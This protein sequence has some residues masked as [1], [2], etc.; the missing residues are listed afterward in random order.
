MLTK[1]FS[2]TRVSLLRILLFSSGGFHLRELSR[3]AGVSAPYASKELAN[4]MDA[5]IVREEKVGNLKVYSVREG[6]P[7]LPE[8]RGLFIKTD[9]L[10][11]LVREK[12]SEKAR[13][14]L[15]YGSFA[16]GDE[17]EGSDIDL[18]VV[19]GM[20]EDNLL[21]LSKKLEGETSREVNY[22][23]WNDKAFKE[24]KGNALLKTI[25][26]QGFIMIIGDEQEFRKEAS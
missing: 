2:K 6:C 17:R 23:L 26:D 16:K 24:R 11:E 20:D 4:L 3:K 21:E 25:L 9:Y 7:F 19:S 10:G 14:A 12:L 15:I 8:L 1:L 5:G 22:I 18:L 13:Y